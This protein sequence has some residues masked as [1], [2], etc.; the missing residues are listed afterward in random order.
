MKTKTKTATSTDFSEFANP[1]LARFT[2]MSKNELFVTEPAGELFDKYL[3]AFPAGANPMFRQRTVYDCQTCKQFIRRLGSLVNIVNGVMV[4]VWGDLDLPQPYKTVADALDAVVLG[5]PVKSVFRTAE[6][7]FGNAHNYDTKTNERHDHFFSRIA[8]RHYASDPETKRGERDAIFQVFHRGLTELTE[9]DLETVL[10][11]IASNS[12]YRGEE[13]KSAALEFLVLLRK[14]KKADRSN[15][16]IWE[17]LDDRNARFRNTV[18]G[19]LLVDLAE[20]KEL[21]QAVKAFEAKVAPANYKRPTAVITQKMVEQAIESLT[22]LGLYG[23]IARRYARFSDVSVNDVLFV[24]N[25]SKGKMKD[26]IASLLES[27]VKKN[28]PDFGRA[29]KMPADAFVASVLPGA[30]TVELFLENRH[31]GNF[32]SL[33][34]ADGPERLFKWNNNFAWSYD[35]DVTDSVKQRVK[36]A[37]GKIDCKLRVSLSWYNTDDLDLHAVTPRGM[38]IHYGNKAGILD[39]DMNVRGETRTPVENLAFNA[40]EDGVYKIHVNQFRR[41]ET[42]DIGFAIEVE[43]AGQLHQHSYGKSPKDKEDVEC[44]KLHVRQG[45]LVKIET[46]LPG[47]SISQEKW[48]VKTEMLVS[49]TAVMYS[50]NHWGDNTVGAKHLIFALKDCKNPGTTRGVYNEFLRSGLEKH[51]KVFEVLG[52]KTKCQPS[53]EQISGVGFT[54]ARGDSV[55][56]VVDG[57]RAYLLTF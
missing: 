7:K 55:S 41:R 42:A 10:D 22:E 9:S 4:T 25:A 5:S 14:F 20:G 52:N 13:H 36:A 23:A 27:S 11:L 1:V 12:L 31:Q 24:D 28:Q 3:A 47:G 15:L 29:T 48:G 8:D 56:L 16:F 33:T 39:V 46:D 40:L 57:K 18:I 17:N 32:V 37:G 49:V 44:F 45:E 38:H 30:R 34:G 2:E 26:G 6:R 19:T 51:R 21:D 54:A 53:D 50:P 35:G 43:S